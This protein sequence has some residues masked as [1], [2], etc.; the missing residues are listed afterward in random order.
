M[1]NFNNHSTHYVPSADPAQ[2]QLDN[3][4]FFSNRQNVNGFDAVNHN[5][6]SE[7]FGHGWGFSGDQLD[8]AHDTS[9]IA[10][11]D[12]TPQLSSH[13]TRGYGQLNDIFSGPVADHSVY[14]QGTGFGNGNN[15][16]QNQQPQG[17]NEHGIS[18][19]SLGNPHRTN[20]LPNN[21]SAPTQ[22]K[23][24]APEALQ[25]RAPSNAS[26]SIPN[27][28]RGPTQG[29]DQRPS[30]SLSSILP[31]G[32]PT[33]NHLVTSLDS[34]KQVTSLR[35]IH[36]Y[37]VAGT[38]A[39]NLPI[40]GSNI[41]AYVPRKS[42]NQIK[43]MLGSNQGF[44]ATVSKKL[45]NESGSAK[46]VSVPT[47]VNASGRLSTHKNKPDQQ[48]SSDESSDESVYESSDDEPQKAPIPATRPTNPQAAVRYD[49]IK[50]LWRP[51]GE[52]VSTESIRD[53]MNR[54]NE[55][56]QTIRDRWKSDLNNVSEAEQAKKE[57]EIPILKERVETQRH[58]LE[59]ALNAAIEYG[60]A[61]ILDKYVLILI[62]RMC[63]PCPSLVN[64]SHMP[65][66]T[67]ECAT[68]TSHLL[69]ISCVVSV[70]GHQL[71][72]RLEHF[73]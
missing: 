15:G 68:H 3:V 30:R 21:E 57:H 62:V 61:D 63:M 49:S 6:G 56:L 42:R 27:N 2:N 64:R 43:Q 66:V 26:S 22:P 58:L 40:S 29:S 23:T 4:A 16:F 18:P 7:S 54:F 51:S 32:T 72:Q 8:T 41:P 69:T 5:G 14:L 45:S 73:C 47:Y 34:L 59:V 60:H 36:R 39:V 13:N 55:V 25:S 52:P 65:Y 50:Y 31:K 10:W 53:G 17:N 9:N 71:W 19:A 35:S 46:P 12:D 1:A 37:V 67:H 20:A 11:E 24:I 33:G 38:E 48:S 44:T 70:S 28:Q